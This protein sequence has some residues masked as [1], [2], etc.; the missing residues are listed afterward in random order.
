MWQEALEGI[1]LVVAGNPVLD[2]KAFFSGLVE[3]DCLQLRQDFTADAV[4][5][6]LDDCVTDIAPAMGVGLAPVAGI[7]MLPAPDGIGGFIQAVCR[8]PS[9]ALVSVDSLRCCE[10]TPRPGDEKPRS[11]RKRKPPST[12]GPSFDDAEE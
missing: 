4:G 8:T 12:Q 6:H 1:R 11:A 2:R 7:D 10:G 9:S 3:E 5:H